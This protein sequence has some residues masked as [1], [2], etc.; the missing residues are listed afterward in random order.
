L[1]LVDALSGNWDAVPPG[2]ARFRRDWERVGR[3]VIGSLATGPGAMAMVCG[4]RGE[5]DAYEEWSGVS[6]ALRAAIEALHARPLNS[7]AQ[8]L[9]AHLLLHRGQFDEAV[10][11]MDLDPDDLTQWYTGMWRQWYAA[12]WAEAAALAG[13]ADA[14]GRLARARPIAAGNPVAAAIVDRTDDLVRG[15]RPR[16]LAA[17]EALDAAGCRY[18]W[19][20]TLVLAGGPDRTQGEDALAALGAIPTVLPASARPD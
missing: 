7:W 17:A 3:P 6:R 14:E 13:R 9:D 12:L 4:M 19:A 5:Q 2:A 1:L 11:R 18:Q 10:A 15:D 20:R 16:L 8:T